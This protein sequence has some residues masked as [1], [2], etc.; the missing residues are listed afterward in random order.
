[1]SLPL[2]NDMIVSRAMMI[3]QCFVRPSFKN[4]FGVSMVGRLRRGI[5][6]SAPEVGVA[7]VMR[8]ASMMSFCCEFFIS[9][10][11]VCAVPFSRRV[12]MLRMSS[13]LNGACVLGLEFFPR[14]QVLETSGS[15]EKVS[16]QLV[17]FFSAVAL[18]FRIEPGSPIFSCWPTIAPIVTSGIE[19][20]C[21][22]S[23]KPVIIGANACGTVV[24]APDTRP[25]CAGLGPVIAGGSTARCTATEDSINVVVNHI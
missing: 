18:F 1:M 11:F 13:C 10:V 12:V 16:L 25:S 19:I 22:A 17:Q 9:H 15:L 7:V 5:V 2:A 4:V 3:A 21:G 24:P 23:R 6:G 8:Y 20:S 14:I